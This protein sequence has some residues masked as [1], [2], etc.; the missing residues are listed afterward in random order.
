MI[1]KQH[2]LSASSFMKHLKGPP[3]KV[4]REKA[5]KA[6]TGSYRFVETKEASDIYVQVMEASKARKGM[7][8]G[9]RTG[10][11]KTLRWEKKGKW[12]IEGLDS[13]NRVHRL[14]LPPPPPSAVGAAYPSGSGQREPEVLIRMII[15]KI[16]R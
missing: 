4:C 13:E 11:M 6:N 12:S 2:P 5:R 14:T 7:W 1:P 9:L 10:R 16:R 15:L 8:Q 3:G